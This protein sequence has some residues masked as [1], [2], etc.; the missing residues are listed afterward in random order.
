MKRAVER[1]VE[2]FAPLEVAHLGERFFPP[3]GRIVDEDI[4][5]A[6]MLHGHIR[7]RLHCSGIR[8]VGDMGQ[9]P[10]ACSLDLAC[11]GIRF[12][13][14]AACIDHDG[15]TAVGQRQRNRAADIASRTSDDCDLAAE[16]VVGAHVLSPIVLVRESGRSSKH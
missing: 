15:C 8:H 6:E 13:T 16:F 14:V 1:D 11:D 10:D 4:D 5:S 12:G 9:S 7:H 2:D 3:Q